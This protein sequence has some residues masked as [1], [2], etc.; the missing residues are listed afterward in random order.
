YSTDVTSVTTGGEIGGLLR[1]RSDALNPA[2]NE[3]GRTAIVVSD[4]LNG[5]LG[6]DIDLNGD[7]GSSV[8]ASIN[9]ATATANRS[10]AASTNSAGSGNLSVTV[11]DSSKLSIYDYNVKFS[12]TTAY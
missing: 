3:L 6:K 2:I 4:T 9:S 11:A 5:Q 1:F 10:L 8:F 12:S 7:F